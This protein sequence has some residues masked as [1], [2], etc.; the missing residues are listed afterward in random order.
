M[1]ILNNYFNLIQVEKDN[2]EQSKLNTSMHVVVLENISNP[3]IGGI[4]VGGINSRLSFWSIG[5]IFRVF[6]VTH[7]A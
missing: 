5:R 7:Y 4:I 1:A 2:I 6:E 3:A